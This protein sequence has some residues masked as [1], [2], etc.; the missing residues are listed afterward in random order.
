MKSYLEIKSYSNPL[1]ILRSDDVATPREGPAVTPQQKPR[2]WACFFCF[3]SNPAHPTRVNNKNKHF[4]KNSPA[5]PPPALLKE[6]SAAAAALVVD[7]LVVVVPA[8]VPVV[9]ST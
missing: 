2:P 7:I 1:S 4:I 8:P 3:L 6:N 9:A 5:A